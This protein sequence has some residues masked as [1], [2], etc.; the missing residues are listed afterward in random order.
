MANPSDSRHATP[1]MLQSGNCAL[2][3]DKDL[4]AERVAANIE[5]Y[6][7]TARIPIGLAGPV[8][9]LGEHAQGSFHIPMATTEG[10]LVASTTRGMKVI[11]ACGGVTMAVSNGHRCL[12][13]TRSTTP[14]RSHNHSKPTGPGYGPS[15]NRPPDTAS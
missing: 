5:N 1:A 4:Y 8:T 3:Q 15:W 11:N 13:F 6:I 12:N 9:V 2:Q 10:T 14:L 7:G